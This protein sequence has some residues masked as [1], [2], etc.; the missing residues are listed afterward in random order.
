M[1]IAKFEMGPD[2]LDL[3]RKLVGL[4]SL[5]EANN[6]CPDARQASAHEAELLSR[7]HR[8]IQEASVNKRTSI[9]DS[10]N[11]RVLVPEVGYFEFCA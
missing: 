11:Q 10:D 9:I 8:Q 7:S 6:F 2:A 1:R 3:L 4:E 5:G